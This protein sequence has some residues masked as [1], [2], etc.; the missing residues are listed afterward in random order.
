MEEV[1][2]LLPSLLQLSASLIVDGQLITSIAGIS[3]QHM[4]FMLRECGTQSEY[5]LF[6][7]MISKELICFL[8]GASVHSEEHQNAAAYVPSLL[9]EGR[10]PFI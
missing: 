9:E 2:Q 10:C 8:L 7:K 1:V 3:S 5:I 4:S 6:F